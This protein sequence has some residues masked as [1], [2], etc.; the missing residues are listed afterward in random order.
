[1]GR[2]ARL[3]RQQGQHPIAKIE[4]GS[5]SLRKPARCQRVWLPIRSPQRVLEW[6]KY[7]RRLAPAKI[8]RSRWADAAAVDVLARRVAPRPVTGT[9][10]ES[11]DSR[12]RTHARTFPGSDCPRS[13]YSLN[14][15]WILP[16]I[17]DVGAVPMDGS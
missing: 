17:R 6:R 2:V 10:K 9:R 5:Q 14:R 11:A 15:R 16:P 1:M 8:R 4:A 13:L 7:R 12:I 3:C